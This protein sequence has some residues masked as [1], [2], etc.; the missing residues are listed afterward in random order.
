MSRLS[1]YRTN[2][3]NPIGQ[4]TP[5]SNVYFSSSSVTTRV[6]PFALDVEERTRSSKS[7][8]LSTP[9]SQPVNMTATRVQMSGGVNNVQ[10]DVQ[11][12]VA[13][14][15]TILNHS[16]VSTVTA[17][18][19]G[20]DRVKSGSPRLP[21]G[22]TSAPLSAASTARRHSAPVTSAPPTP[23]S[24]APL[25]S[26]TLLAV[27]KEAVAAWNEQNLFTQDDPGDLALM[28]LDSVFQIMCFR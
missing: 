28:K 8:I 10:C 20:S 6:Q 14:V 23:N 1:T 5:R 24:A 27:E 15:P 9:R 17:R 25:S 13:L 21:G 19:A 3:S 16:H 22:L 4:P 11:K 2:I 12:D 18:I 26:R 7:A